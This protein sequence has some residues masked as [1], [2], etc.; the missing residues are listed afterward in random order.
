MLK[1]DLNPRLEFSFRL[2]IEADKDR[3][4]EADLNLHF[5]KIFKWL[6]SNQVGYLYTV[7]AGLAEVKFKYGDSDCTLRL[8]DEIRKFD[9]AIIE[10]NHIDNEWVFVRNRTDRNHPNGWKTVKG[11]ELAI[12]I[13][14]WVKLNLIEIK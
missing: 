7:G 13:W 4:D 5:I 8:D 3:Y 11:T 10:C 2:K 1:W 12:K 14:N 6:N 9:G